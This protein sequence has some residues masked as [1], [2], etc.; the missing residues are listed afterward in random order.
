MQN[1]FKASVLKIIWNDMIRIA[2]LNLDV[3]ASTKISLINTKSQIS[4]I[5]RFL[6][7]HIECRLNFAEPDVT[8]T[9]SNDAF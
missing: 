7:T 3:K 4:Y 9:K 6:H 1:T 5:I 2:F 8:L